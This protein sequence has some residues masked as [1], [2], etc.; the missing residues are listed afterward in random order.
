MKTFLIIALVAVLALGLCACRMGSSNDE[1]TSTTG[2]EESPS[3]TAPTPSQTEPLVDPTIMDPTI[4]PN[5]PDPSV[6]ND[7]LVDPTGDGVLDDIVP[8]IQGRINGLK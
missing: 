8:D 2:T 1:T 4:E 5:V 7:H 6:D 3:T